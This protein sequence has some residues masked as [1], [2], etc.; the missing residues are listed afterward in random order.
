[1]AIVI[2]L[3]LGSAAGIALR[4]PSLPAAVEKLLKS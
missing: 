2:V 4:H 3:V 1:L